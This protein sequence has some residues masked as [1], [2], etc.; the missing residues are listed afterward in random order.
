MNRTLTVVQLLPA[1]NSGGVERGTLE[2]AQALV[3]HGH[4][5]WVISAGGRLVAP[6]TAQGS[7]HIALP[8]G[9]KSP[10]TLRHV[11]TLTRLLARI[12]P[13]IVHVRSRLPAWITYLALQLLPKKQRPLWVSTFHGRHSVNRYS[14]IMTH[15][16][17]VIAVSHWLK[18]HI[19]EAY[20]DTPPERIEVIARGV[21]SG[22]YYP[23]FQPDA[24]WL[25]RWRGDCPALA[26]KALLV[27]PGRLSKRKGI[28]DFIELVARLRNL[29]KPVHGL[30]VGGA[31]KPDYQ[32][33]LKQCVLDLGLQ[34][35]L[36]FTGPRDDLREIISQA[37]AVLSLSKAPEAFGRTV[38]EALSLGVP[39]IAYAHGGVAEQLEKLYPNGQVE[40]GR[41]DQ[42]EDR[43]LALLDG[44]RVA[45]ARNTVYTLARMQGQTLALY[46]HLVASK[47]PTHRNHA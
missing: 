24:D 33:E 35:H 47:H 4:Q 15:G 37:S 8:L 41:L 45:I 18:A 26:N 14:K 19:L 6:L 22:L 21:D 7:R 27:M 28:E 17:K 25:K 9:V 44:E 42:V 30:I 32:T 39:V 38:T 31:D 10:L 23:G 13:D 29:G 1:L 40:P 2:I 43:I 36:T 12:Q 5:S 16:D 11:P 3:E 34:N 20:P 46:Q